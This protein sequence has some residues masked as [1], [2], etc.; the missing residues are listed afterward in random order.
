M[1][2]EPVTVRQ[3]ATLGWCATVLNVTMVGA[4]PRGEAATRVLPGSI[5]VVALTFCAP[6]AS[7]PA[8]IDAAIAEAGRIWAPYGVRIDG[9]DEH[10]REMVKGHTI[11]DSDPASSAMSSRALAAVHFGK[12]GM[13]APRIDV[14]TDAVNELTGKIT[15]VNRRASDW[16]VLLRVSIEGRVLGR[17]LAHEIGHYLLRSARHEPWG[18]MRAGHVTTDFADLG[19]AAFELSQWDKDRLRAVAFEVARSGIANTSMPVVD[20]L[21]VAMAQGLPDAAC[22]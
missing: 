18:L 21:V 6:R 19:G 12:D 17:V 3:L 15:W 13:P 8:V 11:D 5:A 16:P 20:S 1:M 10:A 2:E 4:A 22:H 14:F 7:S 9:V